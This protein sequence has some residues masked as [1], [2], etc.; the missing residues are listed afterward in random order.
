MRALNEPG[1]PS[2][3]LVRGE[4]EGMP[5]RDVPGAWHVDRIDEAAFAEGRIWPQS[6]ASQLV[7]LAVGAPRVSGRSISARR[8][9]ARRR[10]SPAR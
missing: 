9:A 8:P 5:D 3:R 7:G 1:P 10:C 6:A 2:V 4:I